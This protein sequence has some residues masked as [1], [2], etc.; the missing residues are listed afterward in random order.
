MRGSGLDRG[1]QKGQYQSQNKNSDNSVAR[2]ISSP[3]QQRSASYFFK[4]PDSK[5]LAFVKYFIFSDTTKLCYYNVK[6]PTDN[7]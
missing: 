1:P 4:E 2:P 3:L 5:I 7:T 6:A